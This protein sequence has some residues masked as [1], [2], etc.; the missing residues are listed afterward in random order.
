MFTEKMLTEDVVMQDSM[1]DQAASCEAFSLTHSY[2]ENTLQLYL[3]II[4]CSCGPGDTSNRYIGSTELGWGGD[5]DAK[6]GNGSS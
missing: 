2:Q 6:Q 1:P 4:R 5:A 3:P